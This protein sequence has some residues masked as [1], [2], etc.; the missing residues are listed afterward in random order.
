MPEKWIGMLAALLV[1]NPASVVAMPA[2][3]PHLSLATGA[4]IFGL[5][6]EEADSLLGSLL[7][8]LILLANLIGGLVIGVGLL[9]GVLAYV[10]NLIDAHG[11]E[12]PKEAI[13]LSL[14]RSLSLA[15][16][17]QLAADIL[18]TALN[19]SLR[20]IE[21]LGAIIVLRTVLN[22]FLGRELD[23]AQRREQ[24]VAGLGQTGS[25]PEESTPSPVKPRSG[26][27]IE[28]ANRA[29]REEEDP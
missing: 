18:G 10:R 13:R 20:D 19:P 5:S 1:H 11:G 16:E 14:G 8:T 17:F 25:L 21:T 6:P 9:R 12:V 3:I 7:K 26:S 4:T 28:S 15:L 23:A 24:A 27:T 29:Q 22:F 2:P